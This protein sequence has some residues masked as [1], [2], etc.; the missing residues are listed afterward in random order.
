MISIKPE[1]EDII[2]NK[3]MKK[4]QPRS[5]VYDVN[6]P[7]IYNT[8]NEPDNETIDLENNST[9]KYLNN[10]ILHKIINIT[11]DMEFNYVLY[12][13]VDNSKK[14]YVKF[15]MNNTDNIMKFPNEKGIIE[16]IDSESSS[17]SE[18]DDILPFVEEDDNELLDMSSS[19]DEYDD[20]I[21]LPEQCSQYIKNNFGIDNEI[22]EN[23]YKGYVNMEDKIY[24]FIDTSIIHMNLSDENQY[25]WVI[26]DEI[27][28]KKSVNNIPICKII[29][30]MF[31]N[32][33]EIKNIYDE[34][35]DIIES[36]IC[37]YI[38]QYED[39]KYTNIE[40][41]EQ[42]ST[43]LVSNKV[44]H[45]V[46]GNITMFSTIPI[47]NGDNYKRYSLFTSTANY[48][49]HTNFAKSEV[50]YIK[51]KSCIRFF[52]NNMEYWAVKDTNLFSH[53]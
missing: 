8:V 14:P 32:N 7:S 37:V 53:I 3:F 12:S 6:P 27:I 50:G 48:I 4:I 28:H 52:N 25:S 43:S 13:I 2:N 10:N 39:N 21:Y 24:I 33:P 41:T 38:C 17:D 45:D 34:N 42:L 1:I 30:K 31:H 46:F 44:S 29:M 18:T 20:E 22:S 11:D 47:L 40:V 51:D 49:L 23:F 26:I 15:L 9:Y 36:P 16:N 35:N 5:V 19:N